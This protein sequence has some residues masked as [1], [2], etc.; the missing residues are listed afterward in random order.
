MI[1]FI[2]YVG[3]VLCL[4]IFGCYVVLG[5]FD[6]RIF[7]WDVIFCKCIYILIGYEGLVRLLVVNDIYI[8]FGVIDYIIKVWDRVIYEL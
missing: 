6:K 1:D 7:I 5:L 8:F 3:V 4:V 2:G